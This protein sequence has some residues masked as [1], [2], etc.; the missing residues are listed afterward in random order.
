MRTRR[1]FRRSSRPAPTRTAGH[2]SRSRLPLTR[3]LR[4]RACWHAT[5]S[6]STIET[7]ALAKWSTTFCW[8]A[9]VPSM[10][11]G[12][13]GRGR[14]GYR[15]LTQT[16]FRRARWRGQARARV[17]VISE[18]TGETPLHAAARADSPQVEVPW[19]KGSGGRGVEH[20][21]RVDRY[22]QGG[23]DSAC[24]YQRGRVMQGMQFA[25]I[26]PPRRPWDGQILIMNDAFSFSRDYLADSE[27]R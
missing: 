22:I 2:W 18:A 23:G 3:T 21:S 13:V 16:F 15:G 17:G 12:W 27:G 4:R 25:S 5:F 10:A 14:G 9:D 8:S 19:M 7:T 1:G 11:F 20:D 6:L 24:V 26:S